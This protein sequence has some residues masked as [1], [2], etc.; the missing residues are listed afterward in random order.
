ML[1]TQEREREMWEREVQ[2]ICEEDPTLR[3]LQDKVKHTIVVFHS[4]SILK[5]TLSAHCAFAHI[6]NIYRLI[7]D[8]FVFK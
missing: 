4:Y 3:E 2:R 1:S 7:F 8:D 6:R 5:Q